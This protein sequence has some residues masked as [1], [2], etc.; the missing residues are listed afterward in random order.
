MTHALD[1]QRPT[2]LL[3]DQEPMS[4]LSRLFECRFWSTE[5]LL[6]RQCAGAGHC[7]SCGTRQLSVAVGPASVHVMGAM[8]SFRSRKVVPGSAEWYVSHWA[9]SGPVTTFW[10]PGPMT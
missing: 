8:L 5:S 9:P 6:G 10:P 1:S 4:R 3:P 7:E 2:A